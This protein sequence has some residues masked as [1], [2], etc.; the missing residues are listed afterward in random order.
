M[1]RINT[2]VPSLVAQNRL[3]SSNGDLQEALTRLSTGLRINSGSDDPAGLIASEALRSEITSLNKAVSNT[4]RANQI[5]ATADSALGQVSTLL[6]DV[7]G[8]VVEAA[9]SGAL[10]PDE[11]AANQ[12]QVDSS[13]EAINR[14]SQT[15]TFQGR[16]L[17]DGSLDFLTSG[18]SNFDKIEN[19]QIDQANLG[20]L[21]KI[22]VDVSVQEAATK[23]SVAIENVPA[24]GAGT[25]KITLTNSTGAADEAKTDPL[26]TA[27]GADFTVDV[28]DGS[29]LDGIAGN[30]L[31]VDIASGETTALTQSTSAVKV[32]AGG[33]SFTISA[34]EG[35]ALDGA[36]GDA[37]TVQFAAGNT[38]TAQ[39][40]SGGFDVN[41]VTGAF[42][43]SAKAGGAFDGT[44]G[45]ALTVNIV[46][47]TPASGAASVAE[48]AGVV[49]ITV[50]DTTGVTLED[51]QTALAGDADFEFNVA[52]GNEEVL[53]RSDGTDDT[54]GVSLSAGTAGT[55]AA[56]LVSRTGD[57]LT[58]T[59]NDL[60]DQTL[61]D[62]KAALEAND[63][64]KDDFKIQ[65]GSAGTDVFASSGVTD[66]DGAALTFT[67]GSNAAAE[68]SFA[69]GKLSITVDNTTA[70]NLSVIQAAL[71]SS[72][73]LLDGTDT[74]SDLFAVTINADNVFAT[75]GSDDLTDQAFSGGTGST[76]TDEITITTPQGQEF[77]GTITIDSSGDT[78]GAVTASV[79][80]NN[81][82]TITVDDDSDTDLAD[83]I[84]A[85]ENDLTG[86][87]A[88]LTTNDGDG[89]LHIADD[90]IATTE[91]EDADDG[92]ITAD[93]VFELAGATGSEVFNI[94]AGTTLE[95]L[96]SQINLVSEATGVTA[97]A[98]GTT[99]E[100]NSSE[101][102]SKSFVDLKVIEEG[103]NGTFGAA[104]NE[105]D[106]AT[107]TDVK[108]K[109]NGVD[110]S[111]DGN[112][113][114]INTGTLDLNMS[115]EAD[116]VGSIEFD[117]NGGGALFQLGSQVVANQQARIG[118]GSV[119]TAQLGG[120]SGKLFE[121]GE[122]GRAAL[123][124]DPTAAAA[125]VD[126]AI[127]QVT[128]LRGRLGAFQRTTIESNLVSLNDTVAN[129]QEAESSIRDADF[130]AESARLTRA[131]ILVQSGT[132]VLSL[133]NQNPQNVLSLLG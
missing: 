93:V 38:A 108:A 113:L 15:T 54:A 71:D 25:G 61:T 122:G 59:V 116:Y 23:A 13:L 75:D 88:E 62:I 80:E 96:I 78:G 11:I 44:A 86:Y 77:N 66:D 127:D 90:S 106:R 63:D 28:L 111:G 43:V 24:S 36:V 91:I 6:N 97:V 133:A 126:E 100:L 73:T 47:G 50:D 109:V 70:H 49:T 128:G 83:I 3:Q 53:F 51:I 31:S 115:V 27:G 2:N 89:I 14:I 32:L 120:V 10:S 46:S 94:S 114:T 79:D 5:I 55:N 17:L 37:A 107:G 58:I 76:A 118:I 69:D 102:G 45:N 95:Q 33:G 42:T 123:G 9:N 7:R 60:S 40:E 121:L 39:A 35:G 129:L 92:G 85:I 26:T 65:L 21:G 56:A 132:S 87:S 84:A 67:G 18:T 131:Q 16:K 8:L 125:I 29:S 22:Q 81:N 124:T 72:T 1:T 64:F 48:A 12:L 99:L 117:I 20:N 41:G 119:N 98:N 4:E 110:A 105:G 19:I 112:K 104:V 74:F 52:E 57:A 103:E 82:I 130:A 30:E 101:Y 68:V 34:K